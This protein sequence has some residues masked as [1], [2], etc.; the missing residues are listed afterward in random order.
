MNEKLKT[1]DEIK[2]RINH[3]IQKREKSEIRIKKLEVV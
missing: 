1:E 3:L 2:N